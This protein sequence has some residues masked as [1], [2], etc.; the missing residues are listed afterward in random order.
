MTKRKKKTPAPKPVRGKDSWTIQAMAL[1]YDSFRAARNRCED[2]KHD[3]YKYYG[4][5][6]IKFKFKSFKHFIECVGKRPEGYSLDRIDVNGHYE[7]SNIRWMPKSEQVR[8]TRFNKLTWSKVALLRK[9]SK[10]GIN[11][12]KI[13]SFFGIAPTYVSTVANNHSWRWQSRPR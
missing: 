1:G 3:A 4:G 13:A 10:K 5:R 12:D 8:N 6:G 11:R 2:P 9:M 7:P